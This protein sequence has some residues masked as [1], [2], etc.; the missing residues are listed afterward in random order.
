MRKMRTMTVMQ[1]I[2]DTISILLFC[3][4]ASCCN[5]CVVLRSKMKERLTTMA[6]AVALQV[7]AQ[8]VSTR[9][10]FTERQ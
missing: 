7:V 8:P 10:S 6:V 2:S 1:T 9:Q 3:L 5:Q 4:R